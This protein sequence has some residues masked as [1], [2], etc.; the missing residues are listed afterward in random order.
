[1]HIDRHIHVDIIAK[2]STS[3]HIDNYVHIHISLSMIYIYI[4]IF[5]HLLK[6]LSAKLAGHFLPGKSGLIERHDRGG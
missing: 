3:I 5:R 6:H 2:R 4:N 1:M